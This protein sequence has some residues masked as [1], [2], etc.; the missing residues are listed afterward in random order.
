ML[1]FPAGQWSLLSR[2]IS[3]QCERSNGRL[4][5]PLWALEQRA[6]LRPWPWADRPPQTFHSLAD[7]ANQSLYSGAGPWAP[8]WVVNVAAIAYVA[9]GRRLQVG[10]AKSCLL[11]GVGDD[12]LPFKPT[13]RT[14]PD[15]VAQT[16][17]ARIEGVAEVFGMQLRVRPKI[18]DLANPLDRACP[19]QRVE[20][21]PGPKSHHADVVL[22]SKYGRRGLNKAAAGEQPVVLAMEDERRPYL[23]ISTVDGPHLAKARL[24]DQD[25]CPQIKAV[26]HLVNVRVGGVL[27]HNQLFWG[28]VR[29]GP[30]RTKSLLQQVKAPTASHDQGVGLANNARRHPS[31]TPPIYLT[32]VGGLRMFGK[33]GRK[34]ATGNVRAWVGCDPASLPLRPGHG[35]GD[36]YWQRARTCPW[37]TPSGS[38]SVEAAQ[39]DAFRRRSAASGRSESVRTSSHRAASDRRRR[40]RRKRSRIGRHGTSR[41]RSGA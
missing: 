37:P 27:H 1:G 28:D 33:R 21:G 30:E 4:G 14:E 40:C 3:K 11:E 12:L 22:R 10:H 16:A 35:R 25:A 38:T 9:D 26:Q 36:Q 8:R 13:V 24:V 41:E 15:V 7:R 39:L 29:M 32:S 19:H 20:F 23:G 2:L 34:A 17:Q 18:F 31:H 5:C 6:L